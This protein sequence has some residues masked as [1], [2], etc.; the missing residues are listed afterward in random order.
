[1]YR[2]NILA[3]WSLHLGQICLHCRTWA[4]KTWSTVAR[5]R[6]RS[7]RWAGTSP[8]TPRQ[9][10]TWQRCPQAGPRG[11]SWRRSRRLAT[12]EYIKY[13]KNSSEQGC[14]MFFFIQKIQIWIYIFWRTLQWMLLNLLVIWNILGPLGYILMGT[15]YFC[16]HLVYFSPLWYIVPRKPWFWLNPF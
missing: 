16:C 11:Q 6:S 2:C 7:R 8:G 3:R 10:A 5:R 14:Q 12:H 1:M 13:S 15:W 9:W 4:S